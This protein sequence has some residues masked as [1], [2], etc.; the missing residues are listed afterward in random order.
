MNAAKED[1]EEHP[2]VI[3]DP[4]RGVSPDMRDLIV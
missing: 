1:V 3:A 4:L 2:R